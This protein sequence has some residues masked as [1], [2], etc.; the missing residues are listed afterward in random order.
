ME[1]LEILVNLV[2]KQEHYI[3][4]VEVV[5]RMAQTAV[6]KVAAVQL[7]LLVQLILVV[8]AEI[9]LLVAPEL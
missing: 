7:V 5:I 8:A 2:K 4:V 6:V 3:Q 9:M 1:K